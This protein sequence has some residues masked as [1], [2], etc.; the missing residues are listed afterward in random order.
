MAKVIIVGEKDFTDYDYLERKLNEV[1]LSWNRKRK[2]TIV[3]MARNSVNDLVEKYR[4]YHPIFKAT[5][6]HFS[7]SDLRT[8]RTMVKS[9]THCIMF[10]TG[11]LDGLQEMFYVAN[12]KRGIK[13]IEFNPNTEC[14]TL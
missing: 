12:T 9:A 11:S 14:K 6:T 10:Q 1:F 7:S 2:I 3:L 8:F 5:E 13:I 4:K